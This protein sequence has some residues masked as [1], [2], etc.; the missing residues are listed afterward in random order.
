MALGETLLGGIQNQTNKTLTGV[1]NLLTGNNTDLYGTVEGQP[2]NS[3]A[4]T[5]DGQKRFLTKSPVPNYPKV[6]N[7][8]YTYFSINPNASQM[9]QK[10]HNKI[11]AW[12]QLLQKYYA[13]N[14]VSQEF[15]SN[16][17]ADTAQDTGVIGGAMNTV[18]NVINTAFQ[19]GINIID[20][21][22]DTVKKNII[23]PV[24][25]FV[26]S[27]VKSA[28]N[29]LFGESEESK[30]TIAK[31]LDYVET[32]TEIKTLS[33]ELSKFVK[34]V[35][36]PKIKFN[37]FTL[38][39]Y[40][41]KRIIYKNVEYPQIKVSFY[42]VK[43]S[44]VQRFFFSYL[45]CIND[46]FLMKSKNSY[47]SKNLLSDY[48]RYYEDWGFNTDSDFMLIDRI[49]VLE[50]LNDKIT[51]YNYNNP[52]IVSIDMS[53]SNLG[54]W[55]P[56]EISVTFEYEGIT[57]DL[58]DIPELE[59][60]SK[61]KNLSGYQKYM[62]GKQIIKDVASLVQMNFTGSSN[63]FL[64]LGTA[65]IKGLLNAEGGERFDVLKSQAL[66]TIRKLGF[67][68]QEDYYQTVKN[69]L[70]NYLTGNVKVIFNTLDNPAGAVGS[71]INQD[72]NQFG[73]FPINS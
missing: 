26:S 73:E 25:N 28:K 36:R 53:D 39:Q 52:K 62:L 11:K 32:P 45:K 50:W 40:N 42:D 35:S 34:S 5:T 68:E 38:N 55:N 54:D 7:L 47:T 51:V 41:R 60:I 6:G 2:Y 18:T 67:A 57:T 19:T 69:D 29:W 13:S 8:T 46:T 12:S 66:D 9:I 58:Y 24:S 63:F 59:N 10:K 61:D 56:Q 23:N 44:P 14:N 31:V 4:K 70:Q 72:K 71:L 17:T 64:D 16:L 49:S 15:N 43:E 30:E 22:E 21:A 27:N 37:T 20:D 48:T 65:F 3:D 1:T 33:Y